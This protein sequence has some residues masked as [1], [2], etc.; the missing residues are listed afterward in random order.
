MRAIQKSLIVVVGCVASIAIL[1]ADTLVL[2]DGTRLQGQLVRVE[3]NQID[4]D[5]ERGTGRNMHIERVHFDRREVERIDLDRGP[6]EAERGAI[7]VDRGGDRVIDRRPVGE[8]GRRPV[9]L[10]ERAIDVQANQHWIDTSLDVRDGQVVF[11]EATGR[12]RWAPNRNDGPA[13]WIDSTYDPDRPLPNRNGGALIGRIG[14]GDDPFLIGDDAGGFRIRSGG[15]LYL[16]VNDAN[17]GD[18]NG[19]FR[20]V[21]YY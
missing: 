7:V 19:G 13:G 17:V 3:G 6:V 8:P 14:R 5:A 1:R 4:F 2:R 15:R 18:N 11:F 10:R 9:G 12:V 16:G 20:V 21:I